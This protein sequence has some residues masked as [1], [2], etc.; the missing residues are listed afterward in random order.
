MAASPALPAEAA[1]ALENGGAKIIE[2]TVGNRTK[3]RARLP[4]GPITISGPLRWQKVT[5]DEDLTKM[6]TVM[7]AEGLR[8][9]Q[10]IQPELFR[11][12]DKR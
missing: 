3:Y 1:A 7:L 11:I 8:G 9:V 12:R 6:E 10:K 5:A 2:E 4:C